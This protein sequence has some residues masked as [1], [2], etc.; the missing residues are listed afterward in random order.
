MRKPSPSSE[1]DVIWPGKFNADGQRSCFEPASSGEPQSHFRLNAGEAGNTLVHADALDAAAWLIEEFGGSVDLIYLDPPFDTGREHRADMR[2]V[3]GEAYPQ[4]GYDDR[5]GDG[6]ASYAH[7]VWRLL[8]LARALL[9]EQGSIWLHGPESVSSLHRALLDDVFGAERF[10]NQVIWHYT[11]GGRSKS[12][13]SNKHDLLHWYGK[14]ASPCFNLDAIREPYA[15]GSSYGRS[16]IRAK[17]GK[18][19]TPHPDGTPPDDVWDIPMVNPM[20]GERLG[21]PTQKPLPLLQRIIRACS[22]SGDLVA[23]LCCGSGT[24]LAAAQSEGRAWLGVDASPTAFATSLKRMAA[25]GTA[26]DVIGN[27]NAK[28]TTALKARCLSDKKDSVLAEVTWP[29]LGVAG[30]PLSRVAAWGVEREGTLVLAHANQKQPDC[31]HAE[32]DGQLFALDW[33]GVWH[34]LTLDGAG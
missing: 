33:E 2:S 32:L 23:D 25:S 27:T 4:P 22:D 7:F 29:D 11:G 24:T 28:S 16:G 14:G 31:L 9:S 34:P 8:K 13:F 3:N 12:R 30:D 6:Q 21:Y 19:Y 1:L 17:S 10:Q 18:L 5:W 20:A 26:C 15:E